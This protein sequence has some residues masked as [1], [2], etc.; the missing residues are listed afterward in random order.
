[1]EVKG[2]P[3]QD[4]SPNTNY[5]GMMMLSLSPQNTVNWDWDIT[6]GQNLSDNAFTINNQILWG[7]V[8]TDKNLFP[9]DSN[10]IIN[11]D[12]GATV[13]SLL[14][15]FDLGNFT[16]WYSYHPHLIA[17]SNLLVKNNDV[18]IVSKAHS[19]HLLKNA[20]SEEFHEYGLY[21]IN[22]DMRENFGY[23]AIDTG[24]NDLSNIYVY[25]SIATQSITISS[26]DSIRQLQIYDLLGKQLYSKEIPFPLNE[27][28]INV[29]NY[30]DGM[31][32][33]LLNNK[34]SLKFIKE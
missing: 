16:Q 26:E 19:A 3:F 4:Y 20:Y 28:E 23:S 27:L 30:A 6:A 10:H 32:F 8:I 21:L 14:M 7:E 11:R 9:E 5:P 12:N 33:I 22:F 25:P 1:M 15:R 13:T 31:Y 18:Y 29:E 34:Y 24:R 2:S 17:Y